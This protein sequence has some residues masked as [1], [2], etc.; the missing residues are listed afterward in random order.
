MAEGGDK[1][2]DD[3]NYDEEDRK[4]DLVMGAM[5]CQRRRWLSWR[6]SL[7]QFGKGRIVLSHLRSRLSA[8]FTRALMCLGVWCHLRYVKDSDI[9]VVVV[10]LEGRSSI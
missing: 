6:R 5:G 7:F 4:T 1:D 3:D 10:L 9:R 2:G 8:Q